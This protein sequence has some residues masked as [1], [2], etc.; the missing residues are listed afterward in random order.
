MY[1]TDSKGEGYFPPSPQKDLALLLCFRNRK[2]RYSLN[3]SNCVAESKWN[4]QVPMQNE[5]EGRPIELPSVRSEMSGR[6]VC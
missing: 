1:N 2:V 5:K 6:D 3:G 4:I